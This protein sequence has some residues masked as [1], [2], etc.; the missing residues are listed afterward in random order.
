[1]QRFYMVLCKNIASSTHSVEDSTRWLKMRLCT[2]EIYIKFKT[3]A[4]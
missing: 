2:L 3:L 4:T 1:M